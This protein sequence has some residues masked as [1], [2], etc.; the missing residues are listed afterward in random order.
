MDKQHYITLFINEVKQLAKILE[1][2]GFLTID[3]HVK[4][5]TSTYDMFQ[6]DFVLE[7]GGY[8]TMYKEQL[9][10][11]DIDFFNNHNINIGNDDFDNFINQNWTK[12][13]PINKK[14]IFRILKK[15]F[16]AYNNMIRL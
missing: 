15:M 12:F 6:H 14:K 4:K 9:K 8:L 10:T 5:L 2:E 7:V 13:K 1:A 3:E 16:N 11:N